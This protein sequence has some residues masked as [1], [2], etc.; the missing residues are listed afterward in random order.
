MYPPYTMV[1]KVFQYLFNFFLQ[2]D[3]K[4]QTREET[5]QGDSFFRTRDIDIEKKVEEI[6]KKISTI[7]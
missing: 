6:L 2:T 7:V 3:S 4:L 1:E 5:S